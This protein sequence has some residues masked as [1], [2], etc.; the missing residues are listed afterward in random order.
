MLHELMIIE[1]YNASYVLGL[2]M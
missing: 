1:N 2:E